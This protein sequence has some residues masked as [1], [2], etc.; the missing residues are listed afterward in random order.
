M[1]KQSP[2]YLLFMSVPIACVI[3]SNVT[4]ISASVWPQLEMN[5]HFMFLDSPFFQESFATELATMSLVLVP[6]VHGVHVSLHV[7]HLHTAEV[8]LLNLLHAVPPDMRLEAHFVVKS[9]AT[10]FTATLLC[11][12]FLVHVIE[13]SS[14]SCELLSTYFAYTYLRWRFLVGCTIVSQL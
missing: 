13:E 3:V 12:M 5:I 2:M 10:L 9:L 11:D 6:C 8:T 4:A 7:S 1:L 14:G